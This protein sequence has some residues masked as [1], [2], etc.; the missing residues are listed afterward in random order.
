MYLVPV[1]PKT[2]A[3][4]LKTKG[5]ELSLR[6]RDQFML[7][8]SPFN[9][10]IKVALADSRAFITKYD[11]PNKRLGDY[12][13]G[14]EIGEMWGLTTEGFFQTEEEIKNHADQSAVGEDDQSYK[15]YV[16][17]LKLPI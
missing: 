1:N 8:D 3:A 10:S 4:D 17:D 14:Q 15:F 5:W 9:Y 11:N 12:Y 2:N 16:G 6:W 7:A 13:E